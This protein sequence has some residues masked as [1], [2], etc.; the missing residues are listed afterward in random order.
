MRSKP[1]DKQSG[2][3]SELCRQVITLK[4]ICATSIK[5]NYMRGLN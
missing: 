3:N 5:L 2:I 4:Q 1:V